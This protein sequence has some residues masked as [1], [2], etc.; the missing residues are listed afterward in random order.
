[1]AINRG[2]SKRVSRENVKRK[3]K[4]RSNIMVNIMRGRVATLCP[5]L[6]ALLF[7]VSCS[8]I[9]EDLSD[10]VEQAKMDYELR[11]VTNMTTEL[12][13]QLTTET[14]LQIADALKQE[15][16]NIFTDYAHDVDLSFYDTQ[17]DSTRLQHDEHFMDANQASYALNLPM[18]R[19]MHG[20]RR[21]RSEFQCPPLYGQLFRHTGDRPQGAWT[22]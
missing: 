7:I 1:M 19:Y 8:V 3:M 22:A 9:D 4:R 5:L 6:F 14:D 17:G 15:L 18:R 12:K 16:G 13:T 20:A 2:E 11:L 21:H 10:C